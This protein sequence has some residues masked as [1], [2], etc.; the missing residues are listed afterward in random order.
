MK[1]YSK[2]GAVLREYKGKTHPVF[3]RAGLAG[4]KPRVQGLGSGKILVWRRDA[5]FLRQIDVHASS[6]RRI[7]F[8]PDGDRFFTAS[9]DGTARCFRAADGKLLFT[10]PHGNEVN[11]LCSPERRQSV[12]HGLLGPPGKG[13]QRRYRGLDEKR[14]SFERSLRHISY[15]LDETRV[16]VKDLMGNNS[17]FRPD[18]AKPKVTSGGSTPGERSPD[19]KYFAFWNYGSALMEKGKNAVNLP[20]VS[21]API[22]GRGRVRT[23]SFPGTRK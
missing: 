9:A 17:W 3:Q 11:D 19:G 6:I 4:R 15:D 13:L 22:P 2:D 7:V 18:E 5:A 16:I 14:Y 20:G 21:E 10:C 12:R 8:T 23:S 1:L